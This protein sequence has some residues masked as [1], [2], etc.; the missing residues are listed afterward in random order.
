MNLKSFLSLILAM[1]LAASLTGVAAPAHADNDGGNRDHGDNRDHD[2]DG[3]HHGPKSPR[4]VVI[5]LDGAKPDFIRQFIDEGVLPR[6]GGLA[7][8]SRRGAVAEQNV[9]ASPSLTAV[10]HIEIATGST[11]VHND[12]PS[13]TFQAI[14]G[15]ISSSISGFAAPIGG[16]RESPLGPSPRPTALP[17]WVQLRQ[18]GKKVVTATWPGGDGADISINNTVVQP[19]QPIRVTDFTVPFGAF[20]GIGAQGFSLSRG[21]FTSD[22]AV[23]TALQAAGHFSFSP[24]LVTSA[25]VETFSCSSAST[26]TCT[27]AATLDVKY[28]IRVAA[29]D[30]TNDR[31]VNYDTLVFFDTA[32]GI[33]AGPFHAPSTGPA[34]V[35]LGGENA[36]F[37]FEG[38]GAKVGAAYFVSALAPDLSVVRFARYGANFIPR[39]VAVLADVDDINNNVGF[40]RPQADFR[41]PERLS[42]G[43]TNFPDLEIETMFED[44][45]KTF[46][47]YQANIGERAIRNHPD[48]DLVMIYI[49]Q[50]DGSEHQFLLT[51]RRQGTNPTDPNSIG[52]NQ[53]PAKVARYASYI[54]F[55]YQTADKAVKQIADAAG[56]DSNVIVVSDHG[57]APFHTSVS[58]TNILRNA[59]IDTTKIAIRTSGP[60]ANIYVNLQNRELGG[61]VDLAAYKALVT[62]ITDAVKNAADPNPKFN[63][64]LKDGR[65]FTV[66]E[67]RPLQCEEGTGECTSKT[68]GQDFGDVFALMAPGYNFD[69][70]Q[71]PGVARL[72]D[73]PFNAAT[74]MLSMPN[75]YGAHGH[76]PELPVMS[77]TFIAAGPQI[78]KD[79]TIRRMRNTDVAPTVMQIL[80][81]TPRRV[82]GEVLREILR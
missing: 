15:P 6:D 26:A 21:D 14:V 50:P 3:N 43:F 56:R 46:V 67:T 10:S 18:Q 34:Y 55:A 30:T 60:A 4:V 22:P 48:A 17:L 77:A 31:K 57:F 44:M 5:S 62:Q 63:F 74:T 51:D 38:S 66:V 32:R 25:P 80:G 42:P 41:I 20:G 16:Y 68:I 82:D 8:L 54:R 79:A 13:N 58:L 1:S 29:L 35:K 78:R 61:T 64:S 2:H 81:V 9:T 27:N 12:I 39:N 70:I 33:T 45:V 52:A 40:W 47:R 37:F 28:A 71:N 23:V 36:P 24:V 76:D 19:A 69:G 53:D 72:G 75:F 49:E 59:G 11:A 65:I 7:R 73:A